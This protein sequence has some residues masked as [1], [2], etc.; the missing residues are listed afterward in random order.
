MFDSRIACVYFPTTIVFV[1]DNSKFLKRLKL[2]LDIHQSIPLFHNTPFEALEFL[3]AHEPSYFTDRCLLKPRDFHHEQRNFLVDISKI[4]EEVYRRERFCEVSV[5]VV[6]YAMPGMTGIELIEKVE[7]PFLKK[8]LLTGEADEKIAVNAFNSGMIHR[9]IRK[10]QEDFKTI[11]NDAIRV[12]QEEYFQDLSEMLVNTITKVPGEP[13]SC[14][15]DPVFIAFFAKLRKQ[16][17]ISEYYLTEP[18]GSFLCIDESGRPSR[19]LVKGDEE[20]QTQYELFAY[21]DEKPGDALI[22][23]LKNREKVLYMPLTDVPISLSELERYL[24]P[25]QVLVGKHG[26]YYYAYVD[27]VN[28]IGEDVDRERFLSFG[29]F[30]KGFEGK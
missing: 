26:I 23:M 1:D 20:M 29:S 5:L 13:P 22:Q 6:D 19:L 21:G 24:Y 12:L 2:D 18:S 9:F 4:H 3:Q 10:D 30:L 28:L 15:D 11:L 16:Y 17:G 27:S 8:I 7:L 25:A 14:L